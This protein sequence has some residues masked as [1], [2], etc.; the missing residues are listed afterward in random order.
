M[1]EHE[2]TLRPPPVTAVSIT[3]RDNLTEVRQFVRDNAARAGLPASRVGDLVIAISELAANT[4]CHTNGSGTLHMWAESGGPVCQVHDDGHL[5]DPLAG[6]IRPPDAGRG[7]GLWVVRQLSDALD[8]TA[9]PGG[10]VIRLRM[11]LADTDSV[12]G[13]GVVDG[14]EAR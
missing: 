11:R 3:Y 6:Y 4:L 13:S 10:T 5:S 2:Q 8:I 14:F 12:S 9:D 1:T 7:H